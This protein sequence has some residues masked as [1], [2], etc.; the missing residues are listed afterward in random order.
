[1]PI[2]QPS[3]SEETVRL[4]RSDRH[5]ASTMLLLT[6]AAE[7]VV[8]DIC[9]LYSKLAKSAYDCTNYAE[10]PE[11]RHSRLQVDREGHHQQRDVN[12]DV[13]LFE[14]PVVHSKM[15]N[16]HSKLASL[17]FY[18][19]TSCLERFPNLAMSANS[20]ECARCGWDKRI[21]KLYSVANN[22]IPGPVSPQ[23]QIIPPEYY[24][25]SMH[26]LALA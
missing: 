25:Q 16:F 4:L 21:P 18:I 22:M 6:E 24:S 15:L 8:S 3:S 23:L 19:C 2:G 12:L 13:P 26:Y 7:P 11:A 20:T 14:Q 10:T 5:I 17:E 9:R 1:M